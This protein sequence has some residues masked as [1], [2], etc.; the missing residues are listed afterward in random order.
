ME[1]SNNKIYIIEELVISE[2]GN[3]P[4]ANGC[5]YYNSFNKT[6]GLSKVA[7]PITKYVETYLKPDILYDEWLNSASYTTE[8][9]YVVESPKINKFFEIHFNVVNQKI[10][11]L[12]NGLDAANAL[13]DVSNT[14][15]KKL[16]SI[17]D[18]VKN[19]KFVNRLKFIFS[20]KFR[21]KACYDESLRM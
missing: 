18:Q 12:Q 6:E 5:I 8:I 11:R 1:P 13:L 16:E 19:M 17:L 20:E 4:E 15:I 14:K 9:T 10:Y 3:K 7:L 21:Q 2:R